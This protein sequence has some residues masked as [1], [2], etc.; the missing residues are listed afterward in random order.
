MVATLFLE[1][2][3]PAQPQFPPRAENSSPRLRSPKIP[4]PH[5]K[6]QSSQISPPLHLK[7]LSLRALENAALESHFPPRK[8]KA[9]FIARYLKHP[10]YRYEALGVFEGEALRAVFFARTVR[11]DGLD[12]SPKS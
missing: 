10:F 2:P 9:Y 6:F 1:F 12:A 11:V 8:T 3:P 5:Q 4:T 7:K